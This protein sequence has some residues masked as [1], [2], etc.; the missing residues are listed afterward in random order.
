ML[1][2][3]LRRAISMCKITVQYSPAKVF[4]VAVLSLGMG[5][6]TSAIAQTPE[7][8]YAGKTIDL[9]IGFS[10]GGGYDT[11]ARIL[12]EHMSGHIPGN[13]LI[14]PRQMPGGGS[15]T[16]AGY[17]TNVAPNDGTAMATTDQSLPLFQA[18]DDPS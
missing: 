1:I 14:L 18:L 15:R 8:F 7:E 5:L 12:A 10:A 17:M 11:Y 6:A 13:P 16:A 3:A 2:H 9:Y 4:C